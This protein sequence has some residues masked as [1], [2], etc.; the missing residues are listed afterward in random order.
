MPRFH[1]LAN[2]MADRPVCELNLVSHLPFSPTKLPAPSPD[3]HDQPQTGSLQEES[4]P[5]LSCSG[6]SVRCRQIID[7]L[8]WPLVFRTEI[9][10]G[11]FQR[12]PQSGQPFGT[13]E[14]LAPLLHKMPVVVVAAAAKLEL[15]RS[16]LAVVGRRREFQRAYQICVSRSP[17][18]TLPSR[19]QMNN[20][21]RQRTD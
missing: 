17:S 8:C 15:S 9:R 10:T 2:W 7:S 18:L 19:L 5:L 4:F 21:I 3:L 11:T 1:R 13:L 16:S 20:Q 12:V 6:R 14:C